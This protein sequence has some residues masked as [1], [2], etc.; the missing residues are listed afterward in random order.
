MLRYFVTVCS[1][2]PQRSNQEHFEKLEI[3]RVQ[4]VSYKVVDPR[5]VEVLKGEVNLSGLGSF[6]FALTLP[7]NVSSFRSHC[8][9]YINNVIM[10]L[11]NCSCPD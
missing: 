2:F 10:L 8:S 6:D 5:S 3:P 9:Q 7:D 4:K 1:P 11:L